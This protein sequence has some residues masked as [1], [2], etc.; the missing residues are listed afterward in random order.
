MRGTQFR[1]WATQKLKEYIIKGFVMD[2]ER[3]ENGKVAKTYFQ[4]W[5]ERIRKIRTS[6]ANFYQK[7]RDVFATSVDY[8]PKADYAQKFFC[9][10]AKC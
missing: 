8:N 6:E 9:G 7:V 4:E 1:I 2:D 3:L 10:S 5:E